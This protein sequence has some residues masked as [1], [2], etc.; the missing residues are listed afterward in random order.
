VATASTRRAGFTLIELLVVIAL[1]ATLAALSAGAFTQ[2][3]KTQMKRATDATL[4]KLHSALDNRMKA[5]GE[6]VEADKQNNQGQWKAAL[7]AANDNPEVAKS[8][9]LYAKVKNELP[10]TFAEAKTATTITTAY[11][12]FT[13]PAR[14]NF[15]TLPNSAS[16]SPEESAACFYVAVRTSAGGG[17]MTDGD[18]LEQ[19]S[20]EFTGNGWIARVFKDSYG[21]P[22]AFVRQAYTAELNSPPYVRS[23]QPVRDPFDPGSKAGTFLSQNW[24]TLKRNVPAFANYPANYTPNTNF[25]PT[26]VSAGPDK[27]Y[28]S[29]TYDLFGGSNN[30]NQISYRVRREGTS[31]D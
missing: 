20:S 30:D 4:N 12:S 28:T 26:L 5:I 2:V 31:G 6:S 8:L 1:I 27:N 14:A 29:A 18:G 25:V 13:L 21:M 24:N 11:G 19:Q 7:Q 22:I 3:R 17:A 9:L 16:P 10:M 15:S 23:G